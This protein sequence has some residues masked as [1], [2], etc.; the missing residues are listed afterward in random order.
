[1]DPTTR[2]AERRAIGAWLLVIGVLLLALLVA[3]GLHAR[4][5]GQP[6]MVHLNHALLTFILGPLAVL[7]I[8]GGFALRRR[9]AGAKQRSRGGS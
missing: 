1:M 5:F 8:V 2:E 7:F 9:P 4:S 6:D 3:S